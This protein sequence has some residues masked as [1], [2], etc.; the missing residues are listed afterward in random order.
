MAGTDVDRQLSDRASIEIRF[1]R[2]EPQHD[3]EI[4]RLLREHPMPGDIALTLE[5]E[6]DYFLG[7]RLP[8]VLEDQT[9]V[10]LQREQVVCMGG[11][12][13][14]EHF[15]N[16]SVQRVGYLSGLRLDHSVQGRFDI[17]RRGYQFFADLTKD[18]PALF[19]FTSIAT[20]N[21]RSIRLLERR[22]PGMPDYR[23]L[24]EYE[25]LLIP[26]SCKPTALNKLA[27]RALQNL[28]NLGLR[29]ACA[30][31]EQAGQ[32][33]GFLNECARG[34]QLAASWTEAELL[35]LAD[36]GLPTTDFQMVLDGNK[37][38]AAT[39][40]W[41]QRLFKQTV[42]RSYSRR[43][44]LFRPWFNA[45]ARLL[46]KPMLPSPNYPLQHAFLSPFAV[47]QEHQGLARDLISLCLPIGATRGFHFL[48]LGFSHQDP[49]AKTVRAA[50]PC[51]EYASRLYQVAWPQSGH[52][53]ESLDSRPITPDVALL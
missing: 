25:T 36:F 22:L 52:S 24:T 37:I 50:F 15:V 49:V 34:R 6:P 44:S 3:G 17:V 1:T 35:Q 30:S 29:Y 20:D 5:R 45:A 13:F 48:T 28:Q 43:L 32:L 31:Q 42:I 40:L 12:S 38:V 39:A 27:Q 23:F 26:I 14:R 4:R 46:D 2:A 11:C 53:F 18:Q 51:R 8:G 41:D 16:G 7:S 10:A 33:A 9:I 19:Y 47:S 21:A